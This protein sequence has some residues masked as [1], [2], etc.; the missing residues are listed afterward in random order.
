M[1]PVTVLLL[2][3]VCILRS[4]YIPYSNTNS[5]QI[6]KQNRKFEDIVLLHWQ[7]IEKCLQKLLLLQPLINGTIFQEGGMGMGD[8]DMM[9]TA[10]VKSLVKLRRC[11]W[12]CQVILLDNSK[13][14][15]IIEQNCMVINVRSQ[16][17]ETRKWKSMLGEETFHVNLNVKTLQKYNT[18]Y[19]LQWL[20]VLQVV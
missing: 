11:L 5:T 19:L 12:N 20:E 2:L 4:S 15:R 18:V 8:L 6:P 17:D 13:L 7:I 1:A 14:T 9:K 10:E 16:E 3:F